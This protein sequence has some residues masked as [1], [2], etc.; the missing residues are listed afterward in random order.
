MIELGLGAGI[1][2]FFRDGFAGYACEG[3]RSDELPATRSKHAPNANIPFTKA[4]DQLERLVR[5]NAA[6]DHQQYSLAIGHASFR[7]APAMNMK[8][9]QP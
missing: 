8:N 6:P 9:V 7:A 5:G 3:K 1:V 2:Q 4:T